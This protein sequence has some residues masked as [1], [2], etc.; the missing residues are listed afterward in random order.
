[1]LSFGD[2]ELQGP[3]SGKTDAYLPFHMESLS[4]HKTN[5]DGRRE[6]RKKGKER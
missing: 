2:C 1:M 5:P 4:E 6:E 3:E